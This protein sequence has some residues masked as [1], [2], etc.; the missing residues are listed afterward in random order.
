MKV[1]DPEYFDLAAEMYDDASFE[2]DPIDDQNQDQ[3]VDVK[4]QQ[5]NGDALDLG[6]DYEL[7]DDDGQAENTTGQIQVNSSNDDG[8]GTNK[9]KSGSYNSKRGKKGGQASN[10]RGYN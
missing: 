1:S 9:T 10:S 7:E 5:D 3:I 6:D 8:K 4:Q 2:N